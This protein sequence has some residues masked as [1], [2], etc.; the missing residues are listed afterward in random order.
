[1]SEP[2]RRRG[3]SEPARL[4]Q[5]YRRLLACYPP[6]Y[7]REN[8]E[9]ILGVLLAGAH[10]GQQRPGLAACLDLLESAMRMWLRPAARPPRTVQTALRLTWAG[11]AAQ[12]AAL[13]INVATAGSVGSAYAR[14]YPPAASAAVHHSVTAHLVSGRVREAI[15]MGVWLLLAWALLRRRNLAR[16]AFPVSFGM[17]SFFMLQA[18]GEGAAVNAPADMVAGAVLWLFGLAVSVLLFTGASSRYYR[19]RPRPL[20]SWHRIFGT[21]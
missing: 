16:F 2:E 8:E 4:E 12:L 5:R 15:T 7:R 20:T 1:M 18:V 11:A 10:D 14:R 13:I 6:A 9:E 19:A 3:E 21:R 17:T